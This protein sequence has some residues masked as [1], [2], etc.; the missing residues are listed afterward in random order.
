M[1]LSDWRASIGM[2][3]VIDFIA[4]LPMLA[5]LVN[6][7]VARP[8]SGGSC[9]LE[10][11]CPIKKIIPRMVALLATP[12]FAVVKGKLLTYFN[13]IHSEK[14]HSLQEAFVEERKKSN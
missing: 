9:V 14:T 1:R 11:F 2:K 8:H 6:G 3:H 7:L 4:A 13:D 10:Y 12:D 5:P